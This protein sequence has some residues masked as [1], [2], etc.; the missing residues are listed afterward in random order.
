MIVRSDY[1]SKGPLR[2]AG[3]EMQDTKTLEESN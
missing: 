3:R 2:N 1:A